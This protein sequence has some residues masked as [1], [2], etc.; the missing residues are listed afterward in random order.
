MLEI[1]ALIFI[2]RH[3]AE[4]AQDK[5]YSYGLYRFLTFLFWLGFEFIGAIF[6]TVLLGGGQPV[7]Y[8]IALLSA[9]LGYLILYLVVSN[10]PD[11]QV[12]AEPVAYVVNSPVLPVY[13]KATEAS[14]V[15][16]EYRQG[17]M[18]DID[19]KTDFNLFYKV[20]ISPGERGFVLKSGVKKQY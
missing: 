16:R 7:V 18:V 14:P 9:G 19:L 20:H 12:P 3:M 4:M 6:G 2:S 10:L 13:E 1:I 17:D 8:L 5:G 15:I 11:L